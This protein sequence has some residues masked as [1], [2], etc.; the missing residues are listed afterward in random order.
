LLPKSLP[1]LP[2]WD[3]AGLFQSAREPGHDYGDC[4]QLHDGSWAVLVATVGARG[5]AAVQS[6][7]EL[8]AATHALALGYSDPG[9]ILSLLNRAFATD[10]PQDRSATMLLVRLEPQTQLLSYASAGHATAYV[11][12]AQGNVKW[13]LQSTDCPLGLLAPTMYGTSSP[14]RWEEGE[15][16]LLFSD[17][18]LKSPTTEGQPL[19]SSRLLRA[20]GGSIRSPAATMVDAVAQ[21]LPRDRPHKTDRSLL[22]LKAR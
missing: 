16:L 11:L 3:V 12:D 18:L 6:S 14:L 4:R 5:L 2:G 19:G 22:V 7:L 13:N 1:E 9:A 8:R 20:A 15:A 10:W 17:G 21:L